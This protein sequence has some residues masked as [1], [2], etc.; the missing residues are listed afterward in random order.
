M[1]EKW[2]NNRALTTAAENLQAVNGLGARTEICTFGKSSISEAE[3][4]AALRFAEDEGNVIAAIEITSA[5]SVACAVQGKGITAGSN[6][7][8]GS[9]GVTAAIAHTFAD[10]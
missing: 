3:I 5:N 8:I 6:Y 2:R 9:T 1:R 7:G 4:A 10:K